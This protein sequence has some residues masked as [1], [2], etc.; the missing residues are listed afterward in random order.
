MIM[1]TFLMMLKFMVRLKK[2]YNNAQVYDNA[3][4]YGHA[5][6]FGNTQVYGNAKVNCYIDDGEYFSGIVCF[7]NDFSDEDLSKEIVQDFIYKVNDS[8]KII[9]QTEY[10]SIEEFFNE[11]IANDIKLDT[12]IICTI[13]TKE[14][15]IK[16]Q[17]VETDNKTEFKFIVD[18]TNEDGDDFRFMSIIKSQEQLSQLIQQTIESLK[19]YPKFSKCITDLENCL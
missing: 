14:P 7:S 19:L 15:L 5:I 6:I 4:I 12:L 2:V 9:A 17:K 16:L 8:N 3:E 13:D 11:P 10:D 18:I 1:F